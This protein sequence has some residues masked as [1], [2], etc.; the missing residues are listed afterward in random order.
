MCAYE[1]L[2]TFVDVEAMLKKV[3]THAGLCALND[4]VDASFLSDSQQ[5]RMTDAEW[6]QWTNLLAQKAASFRWGE[7]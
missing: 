3:T 4:A 1:S 2:R 7:A 5:L 6:E